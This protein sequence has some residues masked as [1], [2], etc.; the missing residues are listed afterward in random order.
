MVRDNFSKEALTPS[1]YL[2]YISLIPKDDDP[3]D[4]KN[5]REISLLNV[6]YKIITKALT[7]RLSKYMTFL[8]HTDQKCGVKGRNIQELNHLIRDIITLAHD[9]NLSNLILSL[10]QTKAY[11]RVSHSFL[12]KILEHANFGPYFKTWIKII[13]KHPISAILINHTLSDTFHP[14]TFCS[15]RLLSIFFTLRSFSRTS[16]K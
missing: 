16:F 6:D 5:Y 3:L 1:Q 10:D 9:N 12:H 11:D 8:I 13:Y 15:P 2:S 7:I 4:I 14:N